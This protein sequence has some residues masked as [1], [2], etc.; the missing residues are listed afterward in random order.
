MVECH[1]SSIGSRFISDI[2][3]FELFHTIPVDEQKILNIDLNKRVFMQDP[4]VEN[5]I[6]STKKR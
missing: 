3:D 4:S 2:D 1:A 5:N 6:S